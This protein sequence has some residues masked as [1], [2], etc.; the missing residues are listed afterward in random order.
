MQMRPDPLSILSLFL[1]CLVGLACSSSSSS[2]G[3]FCGGFAGM[4]CAADEYCDYTNNDC[5]IADGAGTCKRRPEACTD[6][7]SPRC[8][9]DGEV[10]P[11][12]C[13]AAVHGLDVS[14]NGNC[15]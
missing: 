13:D 12:E 9:C 2:E 3:E 8:A 6:I 5:G 11:N 1:V 14:A 10:Y 7:Y 15:E 4:Q